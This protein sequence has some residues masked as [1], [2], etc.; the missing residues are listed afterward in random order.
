MLGFL[1]GALAGG[2]AATYWHREL[3][4]LREHH[5]PRLRNQA[6]DKVEVAE[7]A[8]VRMLDNASTRAR[9]GLRAEQ[10]SPRKPTRDTGSGVADGN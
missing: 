3:S 5:M 1:F 9:A 4:N 2:L 8:I 10:P 6:A 7:Q